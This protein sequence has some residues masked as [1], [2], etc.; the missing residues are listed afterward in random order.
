MKVNLVTTISPCCLSIHVY[1]FHPIMSTFHLIFIPITYYVHMHVIGSLE[2]V[3]LL[4]FE[5]EQQ[6]DQ[7]EVQKQE[8]QGEGG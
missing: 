5:T 6:G 8:T 4:E 3:T 7:Q 2:G 1:A